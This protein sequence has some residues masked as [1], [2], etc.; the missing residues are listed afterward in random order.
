MK[1]FR[2]AIGVGLLAPVMAQ[3][4]GYIVPN[5]VTYGGYSPGAGYQI[6]V[7]I[8]PTDY[9]SAYT[10]F[11]L[12]PVDTTTFSYDAIAMVGCRSF[13]V[14]PNDPVSLQAIQSQGYTELLVSSPGY[15]FDLNTPFYVGI[16][17]GT[18]LTDGIY[19]IPVFGWALLENVN[20]AI[21]LLD[22]ALEYGGA[23][24]YAG[25]QTI[26]PVPEPSTLGLLSLGGLFLG[27]RWRKAA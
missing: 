4:Q 6:R 20:G 12:N 2:I 21:Q 9:P 25:T 15:Y 14:S 26:I 19:S 17:T 22:S 23:G 7:L 13:L 3:A 16:Y 27:W 24:I 11:S 18:F 10:A 1:C 5:G 8:S